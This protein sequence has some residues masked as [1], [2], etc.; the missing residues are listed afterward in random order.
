MKD[1]SKEWSK[2]KKAF[3]WTDLSVEENKC[4]ER[5]LCL[6]SKDY[7][8]DMTDVTWVYYSEK[9]AKRLLKFLKSVFEEN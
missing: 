1:K 2:G 7:N 4:I 9:N 5:P 8:S 6:Q 3:Y